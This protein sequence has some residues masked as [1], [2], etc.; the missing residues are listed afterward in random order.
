MRVESR[1]SHLTITNKSGHDMTYKTDWFYSGRLSNGYTWPTEIP[2]GAVDI[3][4]PCYEND[5]STAGC[6]GY[7]TYDLFG[8]DITIAF[9]NPAVSSNTL[10]VGTAGKSVWE[11]MGHNNYGPFEVNITLHACDETKLVVK[12]QCSGGATNLCTVKI[13]VDK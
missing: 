7:V 13:E 6:S 11:K 9:S 12:C 8:T 10:G 4:I 2:N 1:V 5:G 3:K